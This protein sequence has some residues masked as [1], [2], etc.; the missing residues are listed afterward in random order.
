MD[1]LP[2]ENEELDLIWS[3]GAIY[4]IGFE[5]G[6]TPFLDL[7]ATLE[8]YTPLPGLP[9]AS[10]ATGASVVSGPAYAGI[11]ADMVDMETYALKRVCQ[12]FGVP[13][14]ALR[15]VSDGADDLHHIDG[16]TQYL[17][18]IDEKLAMAV[19]E[20]ETALAG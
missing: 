14:I 20:L 18:V 11:D 5:K 12:H 9:K 6:V 2:F 15:G 10:L 7:P 4:N 1:A 16:W 19:D 3:E 13:L 8:L 17:H